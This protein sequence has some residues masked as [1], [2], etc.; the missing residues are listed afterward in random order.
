MFVIVPENQ[1][2][3]ALYTATYGTALQ[4]AELPD[5]ISIVAKGYLAPTKVIQK[6]RKLYGI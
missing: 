2:V 4:A 1:A 5:A 3:G 6:A